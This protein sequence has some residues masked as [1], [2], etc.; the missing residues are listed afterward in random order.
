MEHN[1]EELL[2]IKKGKTGYGI[3]IETD[4]YISLDDERNKLIKE[5]YDPENWHVPYPFIVSA[6]FQKADTKNANGRIYPR[7]ILER[8]IEN[9]QTKI[10]ERRALGEC[11]TP[12]VKILT[13]EGWKPLADV[14]EGENILTLNVETQEIEINPILH[15]IEYDYDGEMIRIANRQFNDLVTPNHKYPVFNRHDNF[16]C[17]ATATDIFNKTV[18]DQSHSY[19]PKKAKWFGKQN[20]FYTIKGIVAPSRNNQRFHSNCTEDLVIPMQSFMKFMGIY[21]SEGDCGKNGYAVRVH[22]VKEDNC[23]KIQELF[24]ELKEAGLDYSITIRKTDNKKV[25]TIRDPRLHAYVSRL[26][27]CYTKYI[28]V[29]IKQ[30]CSES[31]KCLYDWFVMGDGRI[32]DYD[33]TTHKTI[34]DDVFSVS[35]QLVL[36]LNE[37]QFK[38]GCCGH[39]SVDAARKDRYIGDRLIESSHSK[40]LHFSYRSTTKGMNL[41]PRFVKM[42]KEQYSGKVMCVEVKN[43]TW[44]V[45]SNGKP[46]WTGNCNHPDNS[47][48][49]LGRISHNITELHWEGKTVVGKLELNLTRGFIK[50]GICSSLGDTVA[51]LILN[52]YKIG[53]SSRA[54][55]SVEQKMGTLFVGD[56]LEIISWDIVA[57][58]STPNAW[59]GSSSEELTPYIESTEKSS[60]VLNEKIDKIEKL[61][62]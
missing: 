2:E 24:D 53:V 26:G 45:L 59:I 34:T 41:D 38:I 20:E 44:Y 39:Y 57:D 9:Y 52:G 36:D 37:I 31:L 1:K 25:F 4:G 49:D 61:L 33:S 60:N 27:N 11:Y 51:N 62:L 16:H 30:E 48:V 5:S 32:K 21:L 14:K 55:G 19:I 29:D 15:K 42:S 3:L 58:P 43:H 7:N 18:K 46:H 6:V 12:D 50:H 54:I 8:E 28:P 13:E 17:F 40:P 35:E 47:T 23:K 10:T 56:D 22:Q